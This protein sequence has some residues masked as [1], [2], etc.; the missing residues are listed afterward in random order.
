MIAFEL[1]H[2]AN[3]LATE[4]TSILRISTGMGLLPIIDW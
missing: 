1:I 3:L 2:G 4:Q